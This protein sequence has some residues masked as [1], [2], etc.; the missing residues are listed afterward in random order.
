M[1]RRQLPPR[2]CQT[3]SATAAR[4]WIRTRG[5]ETPPRPPSWGNR[6]RRFPHTPSWSFFPSSEPNP[7]PSTRQPRLSLDIP[8]LH[9][10]PPPIS[11]ALFT[12]QA[13]QFSTALHTAGRNR[14]ISFTLAAQDTADGVFGRH[15]DDS[16]R[17]DEPSTVLFCADAETRLDLP[18][19]CL[20][21]QCSIGRNGEISFALAAQDTDDGVF[22]MHS[23]REL[24]RTEA[25]CLL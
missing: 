9:P 20:A 18:I 17:H 6:L 10:Y 25:R 12:R 4:I 11:A 7:R 24:T 15:N 14:Q 8:P 13:L 22:G 1:Q 3:P 23:L 19:S 21:P 2:R 16:S 5:Q